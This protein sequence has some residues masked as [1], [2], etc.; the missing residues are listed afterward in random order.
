MNGLILLVAILG[1][2]ASLIHLFCM[3]NFSRYQKMPI[4]LGA[5]LCLATTSAFC[6][7]YQALFAD[8]DELLTASICLNFFLIL[9]ALA[10]WLNGLK[11]S[12]FLEGEK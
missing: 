5:L 3:A 12:Q 6:V 2:G 1:G 7:V 10:L 4:H 11:V 9:F 8:Q